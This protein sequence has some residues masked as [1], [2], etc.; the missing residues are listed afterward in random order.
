MV[1]ISRDVLDAFKKELILAV[2]R[3]PLPMICAAVFCALTL[4]TL[5]DVEKLPYLEIAFY[6][7]FLF[8]ALK[9]AAESRQWSD[10][11]FYSIGI[12]I[13][14]GLALYVHISAEAV[15]VFF[16]LA[17]ALFLSMFIAPFINKHSEAQQIWTFNYRLWTH[18]F[19]TIL[20]AVCLFL[21]LSAIVSS[22]NFLFGVEFYHDIYRDIW[23]I[24][25]TLFSP[26]AAMAGI[27]RRFDGSAVDFPKFVRII[28]C[29]IVIPLL[30]VYAAILYGYTAKI[31]IT[32]ALPKGGVAYLVSGFGCL[33]VIVYLASDP[34]H[35]TSRIIALYKRHFF[36]LLVIPLALLAAGI[37]T[38][39]HDYGVT[40][41]RYAVVLCLLWLGLVSAVAFAKK[42]D[43]VPKLIFASLIVFLLAASIGPWGAVYLS[44]QSQIS[45]LE[46]TLKNNGVLAEGVLVKAQ[47]AISWEDRVT[48]SSIAEYL[49]ETRKVD[50]VKSWIGG[51]MSLTDVTPEALLNHAD[52]KYIQPYDRPFKEREDV[53]RVDFYGNWPPEASV[54][55]V[56]DYD[57]MIRIENHLNKPSDDPQVFSEEFLLSADPEKRLKVSVDVATNL[58]TVAI[59]GDE[60]NAVVFPIVDIML[61]ARKKPNNNG[62][63][64]I[65][66]KSS[67]KLKVKLIIT[68]IY[69]EILKGK[70]PRMSSL[71]TTL[72]V[73][74]RD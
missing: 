22:L 31:I 59:V 14:A 2:H 4:S 19:I 34:L 18:I 51:K 65:V 60:K 36:K 42:S 28:L 26:I 58:Y 3:F 7:C 23:L 66:D 50:R 21:G 46:A 71:A 17:P 11:R 55:A 13:F 16:F 73:Q 69:A 74:A 61:D 56:K 24:V 43:F 32:W 39:I 33:G 70:P 67:D 38:R 52:I 57:Y 9:L 29:Y 64:V 54:L 44:A 48:I 62:A 49:V 5:P 1:L 53:D 8:I 10:L 35:E 15:M 68:Y 47:Q 12:P 30:L 63:V 6:G 45:R 72:F 27:P 40:E 37:Y 25:A 41:E 20:A